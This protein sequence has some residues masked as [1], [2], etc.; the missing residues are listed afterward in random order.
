MKESNS[1]DAMAHQLC[2]NAVKNTVD[3]KRIRHQMEPNTPSEA[4][5]TV[6]SLMAEGHRRAAK[7]IDQEAAQY[8]P[9][10]SGPPV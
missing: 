4:H 5:W 9:S 7:L 6:L 2:A 3:S 1:V 8:A 10:P